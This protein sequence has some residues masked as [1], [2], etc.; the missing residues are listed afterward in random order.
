MHRI[1]NSLRQQ[2][3]FA[4]TLAD[5]GLK[6]SSVPSGS[7]RRWVEKYARFLW[8]ALAICIAPALAM[9]YHAYES[10]KAL[11]ELIPFAVLVLGTL[12]LTG[13]DEWTSVRLKAKA[14]EVVEL[15]QA[16]AQEPAAAELIYSRIP[17]P[18]RVLLY[19]QPRQSQEQTFIFAGNN[20]DWLVFKP[21][22][23]FRW[24]WI[25]M[26]GWSG[27]CVY[28]GMQAT[29][30]DEFSSTAGLFLLSLV[31]AL[32]PISQDAWRR[33]LSLKLL[34]EVMENESPEATAESQSEQQR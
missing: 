11:W 31:F 25:L 27:A 28:Y 30:I 33:Y 6:S 17:F 22:V 9:F 23:C 2:M 21:R 8:S 19:R 20:L 7:Y 24:A 34:L 12:V 26:L 15:I 4:F 16:L 13:Y 5:R 14:R 10:P 1:R 29:A 32:N 3:N 18:L